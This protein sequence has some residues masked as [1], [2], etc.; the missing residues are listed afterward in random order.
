MLCCCIYFYIISVLLYNLNRG[1][2]LN[3]GR[4]SFRYDIRKR[5]NSSKERVRAFQRNDENM[6]GKKLCKKTK[7]YVSP[8]K[9][10]R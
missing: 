5:T 7:L 9:K 6:R 1:Y 3:R 2:F 8:L 4:K 10:N